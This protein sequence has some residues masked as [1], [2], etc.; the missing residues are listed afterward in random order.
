MNG[1]C[2]C[3][4]V[5]IEVS[6][7]PLITMACHCRGCQKMSASAFS[8]SV[9]VP[10]DGFRVAEGE[11][12]IGGLHGASRHHFCPHCLAWMFTR[13]EGLD[14]LVNLRTTMLDAPGT[15][16]PFVETCTDEKL[17]WAETPAAHSYPG[18]PPMEDMERLLAEYARLGS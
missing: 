7:A 9:A 18:F 12:V 8:L 17:P 11:T 2:R 6:A 16:A 10:V 14:F 15:F 5:R 13:P 4:Q 1:S 3:G